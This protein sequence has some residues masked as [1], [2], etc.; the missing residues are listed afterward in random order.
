MRRVNYQQLK[1][2]LD[3]SLT[4]NTPTMIH[5]GIGIGK[6]SCV[7]DAATSYA[8]KEGLRLVEYASLSKA[9]KLRLAKREITDISHSYFFIVIRAAGIDPTDIKGLPDMSDS[10][11]QW[12]QD[13][14]FSL[15]EREDFKGVIFFDELNQAPEMIQSSLYQVILEGIV[16]ST[17]LSAN[18]ARLAAGN[19]IEDKSGVYRL[20]SA[21][22]SRMTHIELD[23]PTAKEYVSYAIGEGLHDSIVNF[24]SMYPDAMYINKGDGE[25]IVCSRTYNRLSKQLYVVTQEVRDDIVYSNLD[26]STSS[27]FIGFLRNSSIVID[28]D[29]LYSDITKVSDLSLQKKVLFTTYLTNDYDSK[30]K[31]KMTIV[32]EVLE[33]LP[34]DLTFMLIKKLSKKHGAFMSAFR[35]TEIG[36]QWLIK[37]F[38]MLSEV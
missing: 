5:G 13:V 33:H 3:V 15:C 23:P 7:L 14:T 32:T 12:K 9:L 36:K 22:K 38:S 6:S 35:K 8:K 31:R 16:D 4:T 21:L 25:N 28:T 27:L 17:K 37:N 2:I 26:T 18:C 24:L 11:I 30:S 20:G 29:V 10:F 34:P 1:R 19:R